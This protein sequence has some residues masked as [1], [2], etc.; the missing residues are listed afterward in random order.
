MNRRDAVKRVA[1]IVG[2][3]LT[4]PAAAGILSGCEADTS[5]DWIP[6]FFSVEQADLVAEI[7][8]LIIPDTD[9]PGAKAALVHRLIDRLMAQHFDKKHQDHF[10][11]GL[12]AINQAGGAPFLSLDQE[13]QVSTLMAAEQEALGKRNT[14][15]KPFFLMM[16]ELTLLGYFT[17][18][19]GASQALT[20]VHIPGNYDGCVPL[21]EGQKAWAT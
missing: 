12:D 1:T 16:K 8:D 18:E 9:T 20:Y 13:K 17:S 15:P 19:A 3:T 5:P 7:A 14:S 2:G 21:Q 4:I 10:L 6:E 11:A